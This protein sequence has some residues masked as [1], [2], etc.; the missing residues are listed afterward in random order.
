MNKLTKIPNLTELTYKSIKQHVLEG[1]E[2]DHVRLTED[3]IAKQLGISKSPVREAL[4]RLESEGLVCIE[5]RRGAYIRRFSMKE[6]ED[7][8]NLREVLEEYAICQA[9]VTPRLLGELSKSIQQSQKYLESGDKS[10]YITEDMR[11]HGLLAS[12]TSNEELCRVL[13]NLQMKGLLCRYRTYNLSAVA[14]P[15]AHM[16]IYEA[17]EANRRQDAQDAMR[18]HIAFVRNC[19]LESMKVPESISAD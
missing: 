5:A 18:E 15:A 9:R 7:L 10:K 8:Y 19:L 6:T 3:S 11:F 1:H 14:S 17:L 16:K 2:N 4:N 12:A 13:E